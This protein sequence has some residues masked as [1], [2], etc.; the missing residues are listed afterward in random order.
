M[1][2]IPWSAAAEGVTVLPLR[3]PT[4]PPATHTNAVLV[5]RR[6][7]WV[8]D[9]A[10]PWE[11]QRAMLLQALAACRADGRRPVGIVLTHHH[12]DHVGAAA[13]LGRE[14]GLPILAHPRTADLLAGCVEIDR[15]LAEGEVLRGSDEPDDAWEV[16]HTPGH[17]SDH[18]V[19]WEPL[20]RGLISGD[21][22]AATGTIIVAPP[23]GHMAT[24]IAQLRRLAALD[25]RWLVPA[26][27][28]VIRQPVRVL[29]FY[30]THRLQRESLV[31]R[32]LAD[33]GGEADL[34]ELTRRSYPELESAFLPLAERSCHA[35]LDKLVEEG[36]AEAPTAGRWRLSLPR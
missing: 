17:A 28:E 15:V 19:L 33:A 3:T 18:L 26:H 35:H 12:D 6:D 21:M 25:P 22:V 32:A 29:G 1:V 16:L 8:V 20:R 10:S 5:G 23:D 24:Y 30:V 7:L 9:P 34:A 31:E 2:S 11:G 27:G 13:W 36:R 14:A 4:L